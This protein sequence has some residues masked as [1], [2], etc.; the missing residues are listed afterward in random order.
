MTSSEKKELLLTKI[1]FGSGVI[2]DY[3]SK[4]DGFFIQYKGGLCMEIWW[5]ENGYYYN[6]YVQKEDATIVCCSSKTLHEHFLKQI[7]HYVDEIESG[8]YKNKKSL[9][10][11]IM[12]IVQQRGLTSCMNNTKWQ[13]FREAME[14][15]MPFPP[16]Y[17]YKTL[18]EE[19]DREYFNFSKD[20]S[21]TDSYDIES[22][23]DYNYKI[24][25]W[26][27]VRPRYYEEKGGYLVKQRI[28]HDAE[29]EFIQILNKYSIPYEVENGTY[30]IY[31]YR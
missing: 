12:D 5:W 15:E 20:V 13:E 11:I 9:R 18:F 24:I 25:E 1:N 17:I 7:Q 26:V 21:Y 2:S 27:K 31:G 6:C 22:F 29:P 30:I 28:L 4:A 10:E 8:K 23:A 3:P 16:P 14:C 19:E